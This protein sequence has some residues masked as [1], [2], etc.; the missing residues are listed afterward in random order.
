MEAY[1]HCTRT[2]PA[3]GLVCQ[4]HTDE[5]AL[6]LRSI[7]QVVGP[8]VRI[9]QISCDALVD[10]LQRTLGLALAVGY[11][12]ARI[13]WPGLT[14]NSDPV[15]HP[16]VALPQT[17]TPQA[18]FA[19]EFARQFD[20][21]R[22]RVR[23]AL[24]HV[25]QS[26][27]L[28]EQELCRAP[29]SLQLS[30]QAIRNAQLDRHESLSQVQAAHAACRAPAKRP[31][32]MGDDRLHVLITREWVDTLTAAERR[33]HPL[34]YILASG[35][36]EIVERQPDLPLGTLAWASAMIAS[37]YRP[38][39]KI[40]KPLPLTDDAGVPLRRRD[41]ATAMSCRLKQDVVRSVSLRYWSRPDGRVEFDTVGRLD[42]ESAAGDEQRLWCD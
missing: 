10:R 8:R 14:V 37:D 1:L 22:P 6:A 29:A 2:Q 28:A 34:G 9:Y 38:A 30:A 33:Q 23:A 31:N 5:L 40:I 39:L 32:D 19:E 11:G 7:R 12:G 42:T 16:E 20:L 18:T 35:F 13:W 36:A 3:I 26:L 25:K 24:R 17:A 41:G 4:R 21:S 27:G 15:D